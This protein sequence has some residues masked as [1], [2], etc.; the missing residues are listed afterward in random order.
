MTLS[1][2]SSDVAL[3]RF[4]IAFA[5]TLT[6]HGAPFI[7][8]QPRPL[9][10]A[11]LPRVSPQLPADVA[12]LRGTKG[13]PLV[14]RLVLAPDAGATLRL[15]LGMTSPEFMKG[16]KTEELIAA[17]SALR[18]D[19][20][21]QLL[22]EVLGPLEVRGAQDVALAAAQRDG[23]A[24]AAST[25]MAV[26]QSRAAGI[27]PAA[28]RVESARWP[29]PTRMLVA[30][31]G[32]AVVRTV[33]A[34]NASSAAGRLWPAE[35][36]TYMAVN[37][38]EIVV[39]GM[40]ANVR[41][42][43][44]FLFETRH[45]GFRHVKRET[46]E[47]NGDPAAV[48]RYV[49]EQGT[50]EPA[51]GVSSVKTSHARR[52][53]P[54]STHRVTTETIREA[55]VERCP[56]AAGVTRGQTLA[57]ATVRATAAA[58]GSGAP[59][60]IESIARGTATGRVN[61]EAALTGVEWDV[62]S[63]TRMEALNAGENFSLSQSMRIVTTEGSS[64]VS[65]TPSELG[66]TGVGSGEAA[67]KMLSIQDGLGSSGFGPLLQSYDT[68]EAGWRRGACVE[69]TVA[70]GAQPARLRSGE[71][72]RLVVEARHRFEPAPPE[73]PVTGRPSGGSVAPGEPVRA[74]A[75]AL[76][77]KADAG[78]DGGGAVSFNSV[79]RRGIAREVSVSFDPVADDAILIRYTYTG[80]KFVE[81]TA[82]DCPSMRPNG[83]ELLTAR[84]RLLGSRDG[85]SF[86]E[87]TG[88]FSA[89][90]DGCGL[91]P[92]R[93]D[94]GSAA[95]G[96]G[97]GGFRGDNF[98]GCKVTLVAPEREVRVR[99][100]VSTDDDRRPQSVEIEW[101]PS[102]PAPDTRVTSGCEPPWHA[103]HVKNFT[104]EYSRRKSAEITDYDLLPRMAPGGAL[105]P[106][107][108]EEPDASTD[109]H[110][111]LTVTKPAG[112]R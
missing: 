105:R 12:A 77:F 23:Y 101:E 99:V 33:H 40:T 94:P 9:T 43:I 48:G 68:A 54:T 100:R 78:G 76:T 20:M 42:E 91:T 30:A 57:S 74:P 111:T 47:Q 75:A 62:K 61:D 44:T 65:I 112:G 29:W 35:Q 87:G 71:S 32:D 56:D 95:N 67:R 38:Y 73:V 27:M 37:E 108:Y 22:P 55:K 19:S 79:S 16:A 17:L 59:S 50:I 25:T 51:T 3:V 109:G 110:W 90:I 39:G 18:A 53:R 82:E 46:V 2:A 52:L 4:A 14:E 11:D 98:L 7:A 8:A 81:S 31:H 1:F 24:F 84:L 63:E 45:V 103:E 36:Q 96:N 70:S 41:E 97:F 106:G 102:A 5:L 60:F 10:T 58:T 92:D 13:K 104:R 28:L 80:F 85:S 21:K 66:V 83:Q 49:V 15:A 64:D 34:P 69:L 6:P 107:T 93:K 89:D 88:R 86:Y 26:G 72:R